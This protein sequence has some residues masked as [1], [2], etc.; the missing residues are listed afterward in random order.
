MPDDYKA[1]IVMKF[2]TQDGDMESESTLDKLANDPF[3]KDFKPIKQDYNDYSNFFEVQSFNF[4]MKLRADDS[5]AGPMKSNQSASIHAYHDEF[6]S[7]RS[8]KTSELHIGT[9]VFSKRY[10]VEFDTFTF[11]RQIDSTSPIFFRNCCYQISFKS[12]A[13]VKRIA[14]GG[15]GAGNTARQSVGQIRFDFDDV[16]ITSLDWSD[17]D[18]VT[19]TCSFIC[20]KMRVLYR[21]Q[22]AAGSFSTGISGNIDL[23]SWRNLTGEQANAMNMGGA[24][25]AIWNQQKDGANHS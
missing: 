11:T 1:D 16:L 24:F 25:Q 3:M 22:A 13:L 8:I 18:L 12:A 19:E 15:G 5:G 7:W 17:G 6:S 2:V 14:V 23:D 4:S 10:P 20:K 21:Q 9:H